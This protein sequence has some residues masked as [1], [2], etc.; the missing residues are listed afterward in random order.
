MQK[1]RLLSLD[2]LRGMTIAAML[3]VNNPGSWDY[4][5]T[6]LEHAAWHGMTPTDL[7]FPF[8]MCIMGMS[9]YLSLSKFG[10]RPSTKVFI[11]IIRR[12]VLLFLI[13]LFLNYISLSLRTFQQIDPQSMGLIQRFF[14]GFTNFGKLRITGVFQRLALAY[15]FSA[16][17]AVLVKYKYLPA[18]IAVVLAVY[19]ALL[20]LFHGFEQSEIS[21]ISVV[22]RSLV[23]TAHLYKDN[24]IALDPE[25][26]FSLIPSVMHVL[27]GFCLGKILKEYREN[28]EKILRLMVYGASLLISGFLLSYLCPI[29]KKIWSPTF[30]LVGC[31]FCALVFGLLILVIDVKQYKKW[32]VFFESFGVNALFTFV[33][34][35]LLS[36]VMIRIPAVYHGESC[37]L[38][39]FLYQAFFQPIFGNYIGSLVY[40]VLFVLVIWGI[41]YVLYR[42]KIYIKL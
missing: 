26:F 41:G 31:G 15:G 3:L 36:I 35:T 30:C 34:G 14:E 12:T 18:L 9:E 10:F 13:G 16:V 25:G 8:F 7:I 20:A 40:A 28:K 17:I 39:D 38:N 33:V 5:Y 29:N 32:S 21:I 11:K 19:F 6:P 27:I 23:G 24:G 2:V 42:K 22:D 1:Q 4:V 37:N